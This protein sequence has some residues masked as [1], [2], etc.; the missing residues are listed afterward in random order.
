M[1]AWI[2]I[3]VALFGA[4]LLLG[5][6]AVLVREYRRGRLTRGEMALNVI[7]F[8]MVIPIVITTVFL[9]KPGDGSPGFAIF[10]PIWLAVIVIVNRRRQKRLNA[11]KRQRQG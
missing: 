7:A 6:M 10:L 9:G 8:L 3:I 5:G 2:W 11:T 4:V 1:D